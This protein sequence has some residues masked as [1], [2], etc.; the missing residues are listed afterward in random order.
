VVSP[1]RVID[2]FEAYLAGAP[3]LKVT[4]LA[5]RGDLDRFADF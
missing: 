1:A 4:V 2:G 5:Y 3:V